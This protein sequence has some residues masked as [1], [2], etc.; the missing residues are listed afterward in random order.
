MTDEEELKLMWAMALDEIDSDAPLD[1][2]KP[3]TGPQES[4]FNSEADIIGYGGAA[5]GGKSDLL[6]GLASMKHRRSII[7][8]RVFPSVRGL[9]ERSREIFNPERFPHSKDSF[10]ES[11]HI[12][13]LGNERLLE[14]GAV[15][16]EKD[17]KKHQGQPRDLFAFDEA[18]EFPESVIRFLIGWNRTTVPG[19]KCQ[20]VLTFNPPMDDSG[21]WVIAFFAPWLDPA[22]ENPATDGELR[23]FAMIDGD[24]TEMP[25]G[26]P[27]KNKGQV[28]TPKSRTFFHASLKDN[29]ILE[30]TGYGATIDA[31]P[32]PLRSLLR[33]NFDS[34]RV[35]NPYQVIPTAWIR[36]AIERGN[37]SMPDDYSQTALGVDVA[38]GGKD[39]TVIAPRYGHTIGPLSKFPGSSTPDGQSVTQL[40]I[41]AKIG[42]PIVNMDV[43]GI[44]S[45][46]YDYGKEFFRAEPI[47]FAEGTT[48]TDK[49]GRMRFGNIRAAAYWRLRELLDPDMNSD[50]VL[51]D[52][53]ELIADL[54]APRWE[55]RP[56][57]KIYIES[58]D[59][60]IDRLGHSPDA[61]DAVVLAFWGVDP[62]PAGVAG[63]ANPHSLSR[64]NRNSLAGGRWNRN[65]RR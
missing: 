26:E 3:Q 27:F 55:L 31:L 30:S 57:G 59:D 20:T 63:K 24:E 60:I 33:G 10:N 51:P 7:F 47:N 2:W 6:L 28:I 56:G 9:I 48:A 40:V 13:H 41:N 49:S 23:Y 29:P 32:E 8:R 19:Q 38:R 52:D 17:R 44:G 37:E 45:S 35:V 46:A 65:N 43:I 50:V 22:H 12:W 18:T 11:L 36:A 42:D 53:K 15:Q 1:Y 62:L 54:S 16:Y 34:A 61:G 58:K 4:A 14:F 64:F 21:E 5:G 39:K 25:N